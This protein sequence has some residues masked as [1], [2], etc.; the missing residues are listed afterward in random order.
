MLPIYSTPYSFHIPLRCSA[1][2]GSL[3]AAKPN[4]ADGSGETFNILSIVIW[5]PFSTVH[6]HV[7]LLLMPSQLSLCII[8]PPTA[9]T[10]KF[11]FLLLLK[12]GLSVLI[13][14]LGEGRAHPGRVDSILSSTAA[15]ASSIPGHPKVVLPLM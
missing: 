14:T 13:A 12:Q 3:P 8:P 1:N 5:V 9:T 6:G 7:R 2:L 11:I 10:P 4:P 15:E